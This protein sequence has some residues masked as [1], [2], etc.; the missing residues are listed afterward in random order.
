MGPALAHR[1][2]GRQ[3]GAVGPLQALAR[4]VDRATVPR[5]DA[6]RL[7][8]PVPGAAA[9]EVP[10][11][12]VAGAPQLDRR[13]R[14]SRRRQGAGPRR[15][16]VHLRRDP[17]QAPADGLVPAALRPGDVAAGLGAC[18]GRAGQAAALRKWRRVLRRRRR[19]GSFAVSSGC[20][21]ACMPKCRRRKRESSNDMH[22][23][24]R[25][26]PNRHEHEAEKP[27]PARDPRQDHHA[28]DHARRRPARCRSG[29][30]PT[31]PRNG[32][33]GRARCRARA[34]DARP[35]RAAP[36]ARPSPSGRTRSA[37]RSRA[38]FRSARCARGLER[39]VRGIRHLL[40]AVRIAV[41]RMVLAWKKLST[42]LDV[43]ADRLGLGV[44][45]E[46]LGERQE[47]GEHRDLGSAAIC[48][49]CPPAC[50][51]FSACSSCSCAPPMWSSSG[52]AADDGTTGRSRARAFRGR[53]AA[54][55]YPV[56]FI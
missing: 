2:G 27:E 5:G 49:L 3:R 37:W 6:G 40:A 39:L 43:E 28:G 15:H 51:T 17:G 10:R 30:P 22:G 41:W 33:S 7:R 48:L 55:V 11:I 35:A 32:D 13:G 56:Y 23:V 34:R 47:Q 52:F 38:T 8:G 1:R 29:M 20:G 21:G 19:A 53:D 25:E 50:S 14:G 31:P 44:L 42:P 12:L 36:C 18:P 45:A 4:R 46:G 54:A 16:G 26:R 24:R 9:A